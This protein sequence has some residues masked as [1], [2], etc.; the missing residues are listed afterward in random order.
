MRPDDRVVDAFD[1]RCCYDAAGSMATRGNMQRRQFVIAG[2][3]T[4]VCFG[5]LAR[6]PKKGALKW[7][8]RIKG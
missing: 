8:V 1:H 5:A 4:T 6:P 7:T 3:A 2:L